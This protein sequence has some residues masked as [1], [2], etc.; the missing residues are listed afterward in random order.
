M[1]SDH[2]ANE[3]REVACQEP[4]ERA[5]CDMELNRRAFV[6]VLGAGLL[7]SVGAGPGLAQRRGGRG[8]GGGQRVAARIHL[9]KDGRV[10]VL[11]G[12]VEMGQGAR[13]ELSQ[14]A[15]EELRVP[16]SRVEMLMGD[17][18]LVPDDGVTAGSQTTP[19]TVPAVRRG[20]AAARQLLVQLA[21]RR[22][23]AEAAAVEVRD[24]AI[25][26]A[27]SGRRLSYADLAGS[28]ELA[29]AFQQPVPADISVTPVQQWKVLGGSVPRPNRRALVT[30]EHKFPSDL[31]RP[32]MLY[33][34]VLR[35]P[36][37]GARLQSIDLE[38]ARAMKDVAVVQEG[39]FIGVAAPTTFR[40]QQAL[41]TIARTARWEPAPHPS[42]KEDR[43]SVV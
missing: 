14:A 43:K 34:K 6:Q 24:G 5:A 9:G 36:S 37:Y 38:P 12:K 17:T 11:T 19:R 41:E 33:G 16:V 4:A 13:A 3:L 28:D 29:E 22:W 30:G 8:G 21:C 39:D 27:A 10:T 31:V 23:G 15:A 26:H 20:A 18:S 35:P 42:S 1:R 25:V 40:A 32:G 2:S 7:I